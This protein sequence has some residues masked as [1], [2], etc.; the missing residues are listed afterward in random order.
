MLKRI[1][2]TLILVWAYILAFG[3]CLHLNQMGAIAVKSAADATTKWSTNAA[4]AQS[5]YA[6]GVANAGNTWQQNTINA[7]GNY[8]SAVKAGNIKQMFS[9]G[10]K[11]AGAAKYQ[12]KATQLGAPRFSQGV[13]AAGP[14]YSAGVAPY[15]AT[16]AGLTL[17]A[18]APRG[19][20]SN[21]QRVTQIATALNAK[22]LAQA[23]AGQ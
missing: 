11:K 12:T 17:A 6:A 1:Y 23:A 19:S 16:I 4:A 18:R 21:L 5:Y 9:G 10:V 20:A 14:D 13:Q 22:R 3:E 7:A 15:L 2:L 8:D